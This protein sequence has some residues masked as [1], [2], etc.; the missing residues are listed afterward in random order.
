MTAAA[1][2]A[3]LKLPTRLTITVLE[4]LPSGIGPSRPST[5]PAPMMPAQLMAASMPP[6]NSLAASTLAVTPSSSVTSVRM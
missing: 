5:R 4:N 6:R 1:A 2:L 3:T